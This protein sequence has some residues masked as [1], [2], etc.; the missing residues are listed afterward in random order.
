MAPPCQDFSLIRSDGPR[1]RGKNGGLFLKATGFVDDIKRRLPRRRFGTFAENTTMRK[2]D[3]QIIS[4]ELDCQPVLVCASD[5]GWISRPRL[6]WLSIDWSNV[7]QDPATGA[8]LVWSVQDGWDRLRLDAARLSTDDFDLAG[9]KFHPTVS[10]GRRC[11]PC[12]TTP[13]PDE[14]GRPAPRNQRRSVPPDANVG[15]PT[16]GSSPL[17][18]MSG[19][20]S[21]R[22][23]AAGWWYHPPTSRSSSTASRN[24]SPTRGSTREPGIDWWATAGTGAW[25]RGYCACWWRIPLRR[26]QRRS[27]PYRQAPAAA[28]KHGVGPV[29]FWQLAADVAHPPLLEPAWEFLLV[30]R[31]QL[32]HD[33]HRIRRE[34]RQEI[35]QLIED[36]EDD[37]DEWL[38][39]R[40]AAVRQTSSSSSTSCG[41]WT[42]PTWTA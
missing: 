8:H 12:S 34:V 41:D 31:G 7:Q 18:T 22:T 38:K 19:N 3:A 11:V 37:L 29:V 35:Q 13:A 42:T 28:P 30:V 23:T 39:H 25:R 1:H 15:S 21:W 24:S 2:E 4:D 26:R 40:P 36:G 10:S 27:R 17:G 32:R 5:F 16:S 6:F 33:I 9:L 14:N 20:H